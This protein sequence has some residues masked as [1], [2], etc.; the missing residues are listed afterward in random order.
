MA[1][2]CVTGGR[3]CTGCMA[4]Y[5]REIREEFGREQRSMEMLAL[6]AAARRSPYRTRPGCG[7]PS[8]RLSPRQAAERSGP[9]VIWREER[10]GER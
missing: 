4:C 5:D 9:V 2:I 6:A 1:M 10:T 7:L 8:D 3:E